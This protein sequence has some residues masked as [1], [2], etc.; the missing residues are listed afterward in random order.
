MR[1]GGAVFFTEY[2]FVIFRSFD[3]KIRFLPTKKGHDRFRCKDKEGGGFF[4]SK[5][6]LKT[7]AQVPKDV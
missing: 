1:E 7:R 2:I 6:I 3:A 5:E 4:N